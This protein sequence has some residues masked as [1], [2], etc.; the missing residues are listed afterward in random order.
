MILNDF[1][2]ESIY[3]V[4]TQIKDTNI[5]VNLN[6]QDPET[7]YMVMIY[8]PELHR[9][10]IDPLDLGKPIFENHT[11]TIP[12]VPASYFLNNCNP[13]KCGRILAGLDPDVEENL[14]NIDDNL[15]QPK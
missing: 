12:L 6:C 7:E 5:I 4:L 13:N 9:I 3:N 15:N 11:I 10:D 1:R 2:I 14:Y 8:H